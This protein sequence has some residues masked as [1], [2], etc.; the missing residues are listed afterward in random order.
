M[1]PHVLKVQPFDR[2]LPDFVVETDV[3]VHCR[4][5]VREYALDPHFSLRAFGEVEG[6]S[7]GDPASL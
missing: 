7:R 6:D 2:F 1:V 4:G 3:L 5:D